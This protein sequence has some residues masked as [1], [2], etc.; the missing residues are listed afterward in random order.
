VLAGIEKLYGLSFLQNAATANPL[1]LPGRPST[2]PTVVIAQ[3]ASASSVSGTITVSGTAQP[4]GSATVSTV[5]VSADGGTPQPAAGTTDWSAWLDTTALANGSHTI[6]VQATDSSGST[7]GASVTVS[8]ANTSGTACA[9]TPAGASELSGNRSVESSQAGWTGHYNS[10]S[11]VTRVEPPSGSYDGLWALQIA[12]NSGSGKAGVN[13]V[14]PRWV[15]G[16]PG[17]ATTAGQ[18]Y[19]ASALVQGSTPGESV[20]LLTKETT[21]SGSTAGYHVTTT[22]LGDTGWHQISS[23]YT[24]RHTGDAIRYSLYATNL[25]NTSQRLLADCL[26]L[27]KP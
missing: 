10:H 19:T 15:P 27:Q 5:Q 16:P 17:L 22:T 6:T 4:Q 9:A 26:S 24:V 18:H 8:V 12:L 2:A 20:S 7:G 11:T 23:G 21:R 14:N 3:P 1:P 25:A 13:N